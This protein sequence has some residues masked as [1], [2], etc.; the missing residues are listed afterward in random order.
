MKEMLGRMFNRLVCLF[1]FITDIPILVFVLLVLIISAIGNVILRRV[2]WKEFWELACTLSLNRL[3]QLYANLW[4]SFRD[5]ELYSVP[6]D[7]V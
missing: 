2:T 6:K 3:K 4:K 5:G 1:V 7:S